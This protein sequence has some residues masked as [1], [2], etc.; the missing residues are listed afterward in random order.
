M[1]DEHLLR[2]AAEINEALAWEFHRPVGRALSNPAIRR[3][4][5]L[6]V[7]ACALAAVALE[8]ARWIHSQLLDAPSSAPSRSPGEDLDRIATAVAWADGALTALR[9]QTMS[10]EPRGQ[11]RGR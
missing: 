2:R 10:Q 3:M 7:D 9:A 6:G 5:A 11:S 4:D 1:L 8:R